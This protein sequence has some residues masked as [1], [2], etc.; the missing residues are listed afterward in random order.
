MF[1]EVA[2]EAE[3]SYRVLIKISAGSFAHVKRH[4]DHSPT[5]KILYSLLT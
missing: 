4:V 3:A 1:A 5:E 2:Q